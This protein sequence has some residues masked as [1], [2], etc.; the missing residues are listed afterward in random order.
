MVWRTMVIRRFFQAVLIYILHVSLAWAGGGPETTLL[1]VNAAS[2]ISLTVANA[3]VQMR[4]IPQSHIV[5]L[6]DVPAADSI[7][8]DTFRKRIWKPISD[9]IASNHL[10]KEIDAI[11]YSADFPYSVD[12]KSDLKSNKVP[13]SRYRGNIASLTGLT[14]FGHRVERGDISYVGEN[15]Y[16]RH[17]LSLY[18]RPSHPITAIEMKVMD[19]ATKELHHKDYNH[20]VDVLQPLVND[21]PWNFLTF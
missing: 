3:Y 4:D 11:I 17:D 7:D 6:D 15:H 12:F 10:Q 20:A 9:Y 14:Y 1:V 2:P 5:W 8:I 16:F 19:D 18:A 21:Y 13:Y